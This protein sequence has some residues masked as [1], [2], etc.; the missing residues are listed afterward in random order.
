[1]TNNF[2]DLHEKIEKGVS[3]MNEK[4]SFTVVGWYKCGKVHER[5]TLA[6]NAN[7]INAHKLGAQPNKTNTQVENIQIIFYT[8]VIYPTDKNLNVDDSEK[9]KK[10]KDNKFD[11]NVLMGSM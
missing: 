10:L 1:M 4:G 6:Q 9:M 2:Y 5:T 3:V 7:E 8:C 11:I